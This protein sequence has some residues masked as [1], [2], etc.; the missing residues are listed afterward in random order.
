MN[1]ATPLEPPVAGKGPEMGASDPYPAAAP[2]E[3]L[4]PGPVAPD[5]PVPLTPAVQST[6]KLLGASFDLLT[7]STATMRRASF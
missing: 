2:I 5:V 3:P 6:R 4:A 1:E 7:Q